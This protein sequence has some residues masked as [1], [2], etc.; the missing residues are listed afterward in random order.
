M[1]WDEIH[2]LLSGG[3]QL[4]LVRKDELQVWSTEG[5]VTEQCHFWPT[6]TPARVPDAM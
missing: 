5:T 2:G 6:S 1:E 4:M 3:K